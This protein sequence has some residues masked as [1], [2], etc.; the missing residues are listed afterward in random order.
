[1]A[2]T[3]AV[4]QVSDGT[5]LPRIPGGSLAGLVMERYGFGP[6]LVGGA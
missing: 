3:E 5:L 1:M 4:W 2:A 6:F